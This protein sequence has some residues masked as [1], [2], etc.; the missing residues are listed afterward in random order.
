MSPQKQ[1][2]GRSVMEI[3]LLHLLALPTRNNSGPASRSWERPRQLSKWREWAR[4]QVNSPAIVCNPS[5]SLLDIVT[6]AL[7]HSSTAASFMILKSLMTMGNPSLDN[8]ER[9]LRNFEHLLPLIVAPVPYY[10]PWDAASVANPN[11]Q[12]MVHPNSQVMV[13]PNTQM[14]SH[15]PYSY[16]TDHP[17]MA[18]IYPNINQDLRVLSTITHI[19]SIERILPLVDILVQRS[20]TEIEALRRHFRSMNGGTDL[21]VAF[22]HLL[23]ASNARLSVQYAIMGLVL[24]PVLYDLWLIHHLDG[25]YE[26]ILTDIF[27]GRATQDIRFLL[28]KFQQQQQAVMSGR[29]MSSVLAAATSNEILESALNIAAEGTRPD[30]TYPVDLNLVRRDVGEVIKIMAA[31]F[32]SHIA[33]FNILLRRSDQHLLQLAIHY[34]MTKAGLALDEDLRRNMAMPKMMRKIAVHA[35]RS[36]IDPTYRD[37][38]AL[39]EAMGAEALMGNVN[40]EKLA[41]RI[42]RLH[43]YKQHW[44]EVKAG[45]MGHTGKHLMDKL[46]RRRG[47]VRDLL[48]G[49]CLV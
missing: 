2:N 45:Y 3:N 21:S 1:S 11:A 38:M 47:L 24:G 41:I 16:A 44:K 32:P 33:L 8:F 22:K 5:R 7:A 37:V 36:A 42:C 26:D 35:V 10:Q 20:P 17:T 29:S 27:I 4:Y 48:V 40:N 49:M 9:L 12:G 30:A 31:G 43:W 46:N 6:L 13:N 28:L 23:N 14:L 39:K 19:Q 18:G 34:R 15:R 25:K